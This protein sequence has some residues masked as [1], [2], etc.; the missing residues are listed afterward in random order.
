MNTNKI[1]TMS[2]I[3][4]MGTVS[5]GGMVHADEIGQGKAQVTYNVN[6][7]TPDDPTANPDFTVLIPTVYQLSDSN[8]KTA[9]QGEVSVKDAQDLS[10]DYA[11]N[12]TINVSVTS[13]KAFKFDNGGEYKLV[14]EDGAALPATVPLSKD[15]TKSA[16]NAL[17]TKV[18]AKSASTDTLTFNYQ[19]A[20]LK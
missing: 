2:A 4:I 10:K 8:L 17:L 1:I 6:A 14:K 7:I 11:G 9:A 16:V 20:P 3:A 12:Q 13:A 5:L 19:V 15:T 18:G